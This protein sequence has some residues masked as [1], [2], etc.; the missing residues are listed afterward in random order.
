MIRFLLVILGFITYL[1]YSIY[2]RSWRAA[3]ALS[4]RGEESIVL[5][6]PGGD[7]DNTKAGIVKSIDASIADATR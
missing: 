3:R 7:A 2:R 5:C 6:S 4:A 1:Y